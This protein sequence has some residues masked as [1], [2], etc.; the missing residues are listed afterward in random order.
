[1]RLLTAVLAI[2]ITTSAIASDTEESDQ[3]RYLK[4]TYGPTA[5]ARSAAGAG[6]AHLHNT[7]SEWGQGAV[8]F[9]RRFANAFGFHIVKRTIQYPVAKLHHEQYGYHPSD[10]TGFK[11][12]LMYAMT[13]VIITHKTTDG[14]ATIN[15]GELSG[16]LGAGLISRLWQ[17]ASTGSIASGV[18]SA[19]V[20]LGIDAAYN[21]VREF[22][23][24]IRHP[25][26][27]AAVRASR[28]TK[29]QE[30]LKKEDPVYEIEATEVETT[31]PD[32][33]EEEQP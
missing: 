30:S 20:T 7:P 2:A 13:S 25:H 3:K 21:V 31:E 4:H 19:G 23:P 22:W 32:R 15:A 5:I 24:E 17:P 12:R 8:G 26:S 29:N 27:H 6:I 10:K 16:D 28:I 33:E 14:S 1:M 11:P 9:G 18:T